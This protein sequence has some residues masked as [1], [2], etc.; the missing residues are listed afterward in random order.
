MGLE[1][2]VAARA[3]IKPNSDRQ[4]VILLLGALMAGY[5]KYDWRLLGIH[6]R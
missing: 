4:T 5:C 2:V 6:L 3:I 1:A